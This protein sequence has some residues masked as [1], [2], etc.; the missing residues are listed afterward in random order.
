ML[1]SGC[2]LRMLSFDGLPTADEA[3]DVLQKYPS[4]TELAILVHNS[5]DDS[6]RA[7]NL[8]SNLIIP[9]ATGNSAISPQLCRIDLGCLA[10]ISIDYSLFLRVLKTRWNAE[11]CAIKAASL[12]T[13]SNTGPDP[14]TL[15][16]LKVLRR[17]G[18]VLLVLK[19]TAMSQVMHSWRYVATWA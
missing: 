11:D 3:A 12:L 1:R 5:D 13:E 16:D 6:E 4:I 18:M 17:Q 7:N 19:G 14:A 10:D 15:R 9:S 2:T 8:L